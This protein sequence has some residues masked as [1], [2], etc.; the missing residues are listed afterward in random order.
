MEELDIRGVQHARLEERAADLARHFL[1]RPRVFGERRSSSIAGR[2]H[3]LRSVSRAPRS[4]S[5]T[6]LQEA[7]VG[8]GDRVAIAMR[9]L[10][11]WPA[12]FFGASSPARSRLRSMPGGPGRSSNTRS[13]IPARRSLFL[14][15]SGSERLTEHLHN[16]P[17]LQRV[18]V[19]RAAEESRIR[20]SRSS[21]RSSARS[22]AGAPPDRSLPDV[23]LDPDDDATIFYT[24]GTTGKPKGAVGTHR[25]ACLGHRGTAVFAGADFP[26]PRRTGARARPQRPAKSPICCRSRCS[27]RP[28]ATP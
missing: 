16:C 21:K 1:L 6:A 18:F 20:M 25:N 2:P 14:D 12:A 5:R 10:P 26:A 28:A 15:R 24:S 19:C 4:P 23:P 11:E 8:K 3:H 9:N 13:Q 22:T 17:I 7:G 27:I